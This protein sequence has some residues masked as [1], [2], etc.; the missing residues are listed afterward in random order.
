MRRLFSLILLV[1]LLLALSHQ[2]LAQNSPSFKIAKG[3]YGN[4]SHRF[5]FVSWDRA[6]GLRSDD[7]SAATFTRHRTSFNLRYS[8]TYKASFHVKLTNE[9]RYYFQPQGRDFTLNEV[10]FDNLYFQLRGLLNDRLS[11]A[12]GRQNLKYG[13]GFIVMDASPLDGSRSGYFNAVSFKY[14]ITNGRKLE[15]FFAS[16]NRTDDFLPVIHDQEVMLVE[17]PERGYGFYLTNMFNKN[18]GLDGY[19]IGKEICFDCEDSERSSIQTI[20]TRV[21]GQMRGGAVWCLGNGDSVW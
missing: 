21:S 11:L 7:G 16:I 4:Y 3:L 9:F 15:S 10:F 1:A 20:G 2:A 5:R 8:P 12:I 14:S 6:V 18:F 19:W 17:N 13:R